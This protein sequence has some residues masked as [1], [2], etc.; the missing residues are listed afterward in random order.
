MDWLWYPAGLS[1]VLVSIALPFASVFSIHSS[2]TCHWISF[3]Y[4]LWWRYLHPTINPS[5]YSRLWTDTMVIGYP[6]RLRYR[7]GGNSTLPYRILHFFTLHCPLTLYPT[8]PYS[9]LPYLLSGLTVYSVLPITP[10]YSIL[11][12]L[13]LFCSYLPYLILQSYPILPYSTLLYP[14]FYLT[15]LY[16]TLPNLCI[17]HSTLS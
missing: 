9:T 17:P 11:P 16:S 6:K 15:L 4:F 7:G 2:F 13:T 10:F 8:L 12:Y 3:V 1:P 14:T 5:P